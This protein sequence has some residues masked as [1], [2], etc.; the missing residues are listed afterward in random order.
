[1]HEIPLSTGGIR[2]E[3]DK[4]SPLLTYRIIAS[5]LKNSDSKTVYLGYDGRS[6]C[7]PLYTIAQSA[8]LNSNKECYAL[9]VKST[10]VIAFLSYMNNQLGIQITAS[11]NPLN[12]VGIKLFNKGIEESEKVRLFE[13]TSLINSKWQQ[14]SNINY[15]PLE[16]SY[17]STIKNLI[18]L[19]K[20]HEI[21]VDFAGLCASIDAKKAISSFKNIT[22]VSTNSNLYFPERELEPTEENLNN[23][24][25]MIKEL[26]LD[27]GFAFDGDSDRCRV[28]FNQEMLSQEQQLLIMSYYMIK[29]HNLKEIISTVESSTSLKVLCEKLN[30]KLRITKVGSANISKELLNSNSNFGAEP[31]GEYIF[32]NFHYA[33]DGIFLLLKFL[34]LYERLGKEKIVEIIHEFDIYKV[35]RSKIKVNNKEKIMSLLES[36][37]K[38][39]FHNI[40]EIN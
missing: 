28:I 23:S 26:N 30:C 27:L 14:F 20:K 7:L 2:S 38:K 13:D 35:S 33:P 8:I 10:P 6:S 39:T 31:C 12:Y 4:L 29:K 16:E 5:Y 21:L 34:E 1:M 15:A 37:V 11:H 40:E 24:I 32:K 18:K 9:N 36:K 19:T 22:L 3:F 17:Y 25:K